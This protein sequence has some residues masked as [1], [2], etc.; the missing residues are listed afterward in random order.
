[1]TLSGLLAGTFPCNGMCTSPEIL[2][3]TLY[4]NS[5]KDYRYNF[6]VALEIAAEYGMLEPLIA[7]FCRFFAAPFIYKFHLGALVKC[8]MVSY[9]F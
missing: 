7:V 5:A 8:Q 3:F 1:M 9:V 4:K 6:N 2:K